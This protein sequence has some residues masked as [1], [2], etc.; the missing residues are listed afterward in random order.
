M[1]RTFVES[2]ARD[3]LQRLARRVGVQNLTVLRAGLHLQELLAMLDLHYEDVPRLV[4]PSGREL[5]GELD[6]PTRTLRVSDAYPHLRV[7]TVAH[8]IGHHELHGGPRSYR[9][10]PTHFLGE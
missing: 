6:W 4:D 3:L 5:V 2:K 7:F 9:D 1:P 10:L 8:E